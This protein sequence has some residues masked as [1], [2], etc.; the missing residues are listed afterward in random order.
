MEFL[1]D[2]HLEKIAETD[3]QFQHSRF[4]FLTPD[5]DVTSDDDCTDDDLKVR[6]QSGCREVIVLRH[7]MRTELDQ[8]GLQ[9]WR[10]ALVLCDYVI[11]NRDLM[12]QKHCLELGAGTG[13]L[14]IV[15]AQ[16]AAC[17]TCTDRDESI[18][19]LCRHNIITNKH[20]NQCKIITHELDW[21][22]TNAAT[23]ID[24][25]TSHVFIADCI[26]DDQLTDALF[27]TIASIARR[28]CD[29]TGAITF[30]F[31]IEKRYNFT[32][33]NYDVTCD[34]FDHFCDRVFVLRTTTKS[35][36]FDVRRDDVSKLPQRFSYDRCKELE[37]WHITAMT[38]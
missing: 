31:A 22:D 20:L 24:A 28:V 4:E 26:Y 25:M 32:I 14:S 23:R 13:L 36:N 33:D 8:V 2:V 17:V 15:L 5:D 30:H 35:V 37:L 1:S 12:T 6:R 27:E 11:E 21:L 3:Q 9:V 34:A 18:L 7:H 19:E 10:G 16:F 29:V 38:S